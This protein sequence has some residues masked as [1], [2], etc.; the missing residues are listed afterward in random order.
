MATDFDLLDHLLRHLVPIFFL[1]GRDSTEHEYIITAFAFSVSG[2]WFLVTAGHC[3]RDVEERI[4]DRGFS[5]KEC[6]LVDYF[7]AQASFDQAIPFSYKT[8]SAAY[9]GDFPDGDYGV[10]PLSAYYRELLERNGV[11]PLDEEVWEK[12]PQSFEAYM[13]LGIPWRLSDV[14]ESTTTSTAVLVPVERMHSQPANVPETDLPMFYGTIPNDDSISDIEG[15]S[16]GPVFGFGRGSDSKP[17]YWLVGLQSHWIPSSRTTIAVPTSVLG[18]YLRHRID[19]DIG[20]EF[21]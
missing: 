14:R 13:M 8:S 21:E 3:L 11:Q 15:M 17:R 18:K 4:E 9:F 12:Q 7:G 20:G 5:I 10:I 6:S 16:G 19:R 2:N 1:W